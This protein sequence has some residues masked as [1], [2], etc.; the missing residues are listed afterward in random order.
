VVV[1]SRLLVIASGTGMAVLLAAGCA[2]ANAGPPAA[3]TAARAPAARPA[4]SS[5]APSASPA[6]S[7][8]K[9]PVPRFS[10]GVSGPLTAHDVRY[11]WRP[12]CPVPPRELRAIHMPYIGFD[13]VAHEGELI[14]NARVVRKVINVFA[15][16]YRARFPIRRM[17]PAGAY[18][19]SDPRSMAADNTSGFNCRRA[20]APGPPQWSMHA[21][22]L[23]IDV[24]TV[25]NPYVEAG[26]GVQP[27]AGAAYLNRSDIRR[28]MG[29]PGGV[30]V[31]AFTA[32]GW[33]W[34]GNW[35][36]SPDYQ[37]FSSSGS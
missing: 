16:L 35:S 11:S 18:H 10:A 26:A 4:A 36:G 27:P 32:I 31:K 20:V 24:N 9:A 14:V 1:T 25:Q 37:H 19:G 7:P 33:G 30:L 15:R 12:G 22:G 29:Y 3:G 13:R 6:P 21:Y 34:G 5:P 23:A 28:G 8:G 2:S 17:Q